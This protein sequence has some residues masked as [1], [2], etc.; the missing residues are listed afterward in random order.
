MA[1]QLASATQAFAQTDRK[2]PLV[3][4]LD[5]SD[6]ADWWAVLQQKLRELGYVD[7]RNIAF[8]VRT[9]KGALEQLSAMESSSVSTSP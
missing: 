7:G 5:A 2:A 3:A 4:H 6:R 1:T 9:A 8:E